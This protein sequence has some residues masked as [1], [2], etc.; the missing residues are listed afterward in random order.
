M[1]SSFFS[2][3]F[4]LLA[5]SLYISCNGHRAGE[6]PTVS[7]RTDTLQSPRRPDAQAQITMAI[8]Q[9]GKLYTTEY[10]IHKVVLCTDHATIGGKLTDIPLPGTRKAAVPITVTLRAYV[11]FSQFSAENVQIIDS[12]CIVT[13]PDP[14]IIVS[15]S[16]I[17][18]AK[19][20]QYVSMA[21]SRFSEA[22]ISRLAAQGE[23]SIVS[24]ISRYGMIEQS[25]M[26]F[27][28][29][30]VPMLETMGF[31]AHNVIIRF[32]KDYSEADIRSL[33]IIEQAK[34]LD[35]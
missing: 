20:R 33:T 27:T 34:P 31:D 3:L 5:G 17:N 12:L 35:K 25:R 30:F 7:P 11:D 6:S 16:R 28:R 23:D 8:Q 21:R 10:Q 18:H 32:R 9:Q 13:L 1:K 15:S 19:V 2:L 29:V 24:H 22:E 4:L 26:D 14:H